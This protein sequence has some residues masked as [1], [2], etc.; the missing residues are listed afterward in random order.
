MKKALKIIGI[1]LGSIIVI[2]GL[3]LTFIRFKPLPTYEIQTKDLKVEVTP[4]RVEKGMALAQAICATCHM[5][6][7][8]SF[9]GR[10]LIEEPGIGVV[11]APNITQHKTFGI[12]NYTD[13][14][15]YYLFRTGVKRDGELALPMMWRSVHMSD[16]DMYSLIAY[17]KSDNH[18]VQPSETQHP[19][20]EQNLLTR[21]LF[22]LAWKP[23][24]LPESPVVAPDISN[25][26]EYG[27][28]IVQGQGSIRALSLFFVIL[29]GPRDYREGFW[30]FLWGVKP[31]GK[32]QRHFPYVQ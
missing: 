16:E 20:F 11:Y 32:S 24:D 30:A 10:K 3:V 23:M 22:T 4:A 19:K 7:N 27:K 1:T 25:E 6:E 12:G 26:V 18:S 14:E 28:Y 8:N 5:G 21:A 9:E 2:I 15:L 29:F 31:P 13:G 17:L